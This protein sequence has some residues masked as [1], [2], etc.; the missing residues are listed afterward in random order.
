MTPEKLNEILNIKN[1]REQMFL[2]EYCDPYTYMD[3]NGGELV[4]VCRPII[5]KEALEFQSV[6]IAMILEVLSE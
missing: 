4:G 2:D 1:L 6:T 5:A 3:V